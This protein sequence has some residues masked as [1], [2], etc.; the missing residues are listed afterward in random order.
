MPD[1]QSV[2][3]VRYERNHG[4]EP[5][6][7]LE[8]NGR[9]TQLH[10]DQKLMKFGAVF[11]GQGFDDFS[12]IVPADASDGRP[13]P[14]EMTRFSNDVRLVRLVRRLIDDVDS[15]RFRPG[16]IDL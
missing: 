13:E 14:Q 1:I 2:T 9:V 4:D 7:I 12:F 11:L 8:V 3:N 15:G 6:L 10:Y 16:A 5:Y